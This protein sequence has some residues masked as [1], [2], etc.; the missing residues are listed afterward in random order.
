MKNY[1][2][3]FIIVLLAGCTSDVFTP[4]PLLPVKAALTFPA[5]DAICT[6]GT[7]LSATQS[8]ITFTWNTAANTTSYDFTLKNLITAAIITQTTTNTQLTV[9]LLRNTPYSWYV[10]SKSTKTNE[11]A[12]S[13]VWKFYN[14]GP[15]TVS[16]PPFP[17][18]IIS[19]VMGQNINATNGKINLT[20]A[21]NDV[22]ND[23]T[24]YEVYFGDTTIPPLLQAN[25]TTPVL[26]NVNVV[27]GKTYYWKIVTKDAAGNMSTSSLSQFSIN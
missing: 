7:V 12:Q 1:C 23:I 2:L 21:G 25:L 11:T 4:Q 26:N 16:Y 18:D 6:T 19:P 3:I 24:S 15:A 14:S 10:T 9:N 27:P 5:K 8:N 20:W 13:E 17:A 22:D